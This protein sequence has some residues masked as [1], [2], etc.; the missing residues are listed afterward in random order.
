MKKWEENNKLKIHQKKIQNAKS[1]V[2]PKAPAKP[3]SADIRP[4]SSQK[5]LLAS[6]SYYIGVQSNHSPSPQRGE[7]ANSIRT[8]S[9]GISDYFEHEKYDLNMIPLYKLLKFYN[10]QQYAKVITND[11]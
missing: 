11:N 4:N 1:T 6:P 10:L 8:S 3:T 7:T 5:N 2:N 9:I